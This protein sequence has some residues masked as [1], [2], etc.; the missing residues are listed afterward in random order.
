MTSRADTPRKR[1]AWR[2]W[3]APYLARYARSLAAAIVL[4]ALAIG[5]AAALMFTS[6]YLISGSAEVETIL[7]LHLPLLFV[8]I[9]GIGK[10]VIGYFQRL[11]SHDWV[12]RMTSRMRLEL[13][14]SLSAQTI[15]ERAAQRVGDALGL[16]AD[17]IG[18]LQNL[19]VRCVLP[20]V[21]AWI[22]Y[23]A[24]VAG[25]GLMD[26]WIGLSM[27]L[28]V[29][30]IV[31]VAPIVSVAANGAREAR[32]KQ[33]RASLYADLAD[34]VLGIEDWTYAQRSDDYLSRFDGIARQLRA[35]DERMDRFDRVRAVV[36]EAA[37]ALAVVA[38]I[39]WAAGA[40]GGTQG[41]AA[42]WIAAVALGIFPLV[43][44]F[45]PMPAAAQETFAHRDS[46]HRLAALPDPDAPAAAEDGMTS[47]RAPRDERSGEADAE[48]GVRGK[49]S[50]IEV[51]GA[52]FAYPG[53]ASPVIDGLDLIVPAGQKVALLGR[54]GA[55][56]STLAALVRG[57]LVPS[58]GRVLV[59]GRDACRL[60]EDAVRLVGVIGQSPYLFHD[61]LLENVRIGKP[62]ASEEEVRDALTAVGLGAR[63]EALEDGLRSAVG[64]GGFG[65]SGGERHRIALARVLLQNTPIVILDEPC[66]GLD[67]ATE[68][69]LVDTFFDVL[70]DR[71]VIMITH[72]LAGA[73]RADRIVFLDGGSVRRDGETPLDGSP[74][75]L[76]RTSAYFRRLLAFDEGFCATR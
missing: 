47:G 73:E 14:R 13:Y 58:A 24:L 51:R 76:A 74:A 75:D 16:L 71:T 43:D 12:L 36:V 2:R 42:N 53:A 1:T 59:E 48:D 22:A 57:D 17:D 54:S 3:V 8:R 40:F 26:A 56:K 64:E 19:Y 33:L 65:F 37:F 35:L 7:A 29:G 21:V 32:R 20:S 5:F 49:V 44:A 25:F 9:F 11:A 67:P 4:G 10:P 63:V 6:G 50:A 60:G 38:A 31:V 72:H 30:I 69:S 70:A 41:G 27:L 39:V 66:A 68:R 18:H 34:N 52:S 15:A 46:L 62:D 28:T 45:A 23:A 61:T 55:G